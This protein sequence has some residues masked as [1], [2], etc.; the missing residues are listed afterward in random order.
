MSAEQICN[1]APP[2]VKKMLKKIRAKAVRRAWK[3]KG[4]SDFRGIRGWSD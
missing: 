4:V 3:Q 1:N 2:R